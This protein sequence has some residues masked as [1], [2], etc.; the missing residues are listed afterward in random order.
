M[1]RIVD[2]PYPLKALPSM[3]QNLVS[4]LHTNT[5]APIELIAPVVLGT[6]SLVCQ[7]SIDVRRPNCS[8]SACS[9][10]ILLI[11]GSG[12]GKSTIS[13]LLSKPIHDFE[14]SNLNE[15]VLRLAEF[16]GL[17]MAWNAEHKTL[18]SALKKLAAKGE[19]TEPLKLNLTQLFS[20][21]PKR[22]L[23]PKLIYND[24]TPEAVIQG[25][26]ERW[27]SAALISDEGGSFF[28]GRAI[29]DLPM[30]NKGWDGKSIAVD[31]RSSASFSHCAPRLG[32]LVSVQS[33]P[34][35]RFYER[36]GKEAQESGFLPR[37][38]VA[39][40]ASTRGTRFLGNKTCVWPALN[41]YNKRAAEILNA[42]KSLID[43]EQTDRLVLDFSQ[44]AST[45]WTNVY[46]NVEKLAAPGEYLSDMPGYAAKVADNI[47]RV[48]AIFHFFEGH[49]EKISCE[50]VRSATEICEWHC[51][52][53][54]KIFPADANIPIEQSDAESIEIWLRD[55]IWNRGNKWVKKNYIRQRGPNVIRNK[56]RLENALDVLVLNGKISIGFDFKEAKIIDLNPY[57]FQNNP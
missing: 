40:P 9:L 5:G 20:K 54:K 45:Y 44:E 16:E 35:Q 6:V 18:Q 14:A 7:N 50:T 49:S 42:N 4:E 38:L 43:E 21:K 25:L 30:W 55:F 27:P 32:I 36:Q 24:A 8:P 57:Y 19:S 17:Q 12:E 3:L 2:E 15:N 37:F 39:S 47:A 23:A 53:Y 1:S 51:T 26:C 33:A 29:Q 34:F 28:N 48:A 41:Q 31:R 10:Y 13:D 46:N 52:E 11:A 56:V 22:P